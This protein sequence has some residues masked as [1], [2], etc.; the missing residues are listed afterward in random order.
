MAYFKTQDFISQVR[1]D[2]LARSNRFEV[3]ILSPQ[4]HRADREVSL[5]CEEAQIPGLQ[6]KWSPTMIGAWTEQRAHGIEYFGDTA[7]FTFFCDDNWDIRTYFESWMTLIADPITKEVTFPDAYNGQ[8]EVYSLDRADNRV[9]K[10]KLHD[11]FPRLL[12]ILPMGQS[13]E[14]IVRV[15]VTFAFRRWTSKGVDASDSQNLFGILDFR[16]GSIGSAIKNKI[17]HNVLD[18]LD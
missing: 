10:W 13:A 6:L 9:A 11:A 17:A 3:V 4:K 12:N 1:K 7:A 14:G 16:K 5:Y 18:R 8:I 2:D 15:N